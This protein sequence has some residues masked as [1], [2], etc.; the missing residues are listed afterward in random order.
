MRGQELPSLSLIGWGNRPLQR[1]RCL[2]TAWLSARP[3][4]QNK[5]PDEYERRDLSSFVEATLAVL[6]VCELGY[7]GQLRELVRYAGVGR[8]TF[9]AR[10][11]HF[12]R[13]NDRLD[14]PKKVARQ[15]WVERNIG[16]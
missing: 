7:A 8:D 13:T 10:C 3:S 12:D 16:G 5:H 2:F 6:S 14:F 11:G 9:C 1:L 4:R 15:Q